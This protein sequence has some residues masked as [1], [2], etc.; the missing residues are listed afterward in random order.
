MKLWNKIKIILPVF[1][2]TVLLASCRMGE[3]RFELTNYM[4]NS[5]K[6]FEKRT[7]IKLEERS[8]NVYAKQ[9]V[10]QVIAP[11]G[12]IKAVSLMK[13]GGEYKIF[14]ITIGMPKADAQQ[15]C[16]TSFG[17]DNSRT[18]NSAENSVTYSYLKG[19]EELYISYSVDT[20][21]V[22]EISYFKMKVLKEETTENRDVNAGE[23]MAIIGT[24]R[25]YYNEAIVYL[26]SVQ[27]EYETEYGDNIWD[28]DILGNGR[29]FGEMMKDEVIKQITELKVLKSKAQ[30]M[31]IA[32]EED[33][34]AQAKV[35]A[36]DHY[37]GLST[38]DINHYAIT[39]ELLQN[40]YEDNLLAQKVY[41]NATINV[42]TNV[43]DEQ[44]KQ[45]TI[46][47]ILIHSVTKDNKG[48]KVALSQ[49]DKQKA[50]EKAQNLLKQ[51]KSTDDFYSLAEANSESDQ[52]EFT[53]GK[54]QAPKDYSPAF[55]TAA[56]ALKTGEVSGLIETDYGWHILYCVS[57]F[58]ED[59]TTQVKETMIEQR[60]S[61]MFAKLYSGWS[62]QYDVIVNSEAWNKI[63]LKKQ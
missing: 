47:Q 22:T 11:D 20:Q 56:F 58:N 26:K 57:D 18:I 38:D 10:A 45:I 4:G 43:A 27:E 63:S 62:S 3:E 14:G 16:Q 60:R 34:I 28:V 59:A 17:K 50:L 40:I 31:G 32:L 41:E 51:A 12:H 53:F 2:L 36:Q 21:V 24:S 30:E 46:Q 1:L 49:E 39:Q 37:A 6:S 7:E 52:I 54:G 42:D 48:N 44:A 9:D 33:E 5:V 25:V 29:T 19:D 23:L 8:N 61:D 55:E 15:K 13:D 35:Y